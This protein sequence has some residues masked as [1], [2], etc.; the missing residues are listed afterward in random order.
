MSSGRLEQAYYSLLALV[1]ESAHIYTPLA[2]RVPG[3][4]P[5]FPFPDCPA[6]FADLIAWDGPAVEGSFI[7]FAF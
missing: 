1:C 3:L 5:V 2:E 6:A 4:L 7:P